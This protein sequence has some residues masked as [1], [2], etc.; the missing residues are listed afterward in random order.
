MNLILIEPPELEAGAGAAAGVEAGTPA[1]GERS[2]RRGTVRLRDRR[3][4]HLIDVLGVT[5]GATVRVGLLDGPLGEG[6]VIAVGRGEVSLRCRFER[7]VPPRPRVDLLL[8]MPRPK[9]LKRL[10]APLASLGV[11]RVLLTR[12][13]KVEKA[14]FD[15]HAVDPSRIRPRLL[16]GLEQ[17]LD[18]RLPEVEVH[19]RFRPLVQDRLPELGPYERRLVADPAYAASSRSAVRGVAGRALLGVGPEGGWTDVERDLLE[20]QGFVGV[21]LGPRVLRTDVAVVA[22]LAL[23]RDGME[24][25][26]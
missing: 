21:G 17:A 8:A 26:C 11:G 12:A 10:W 7:G 25:A 13:E 1:E 23:L 3:A 4:R 22:L 2:A 19:R 24:A 15:S 14:Y 6:E 20:A 18:T 5:P 9:V 16:E